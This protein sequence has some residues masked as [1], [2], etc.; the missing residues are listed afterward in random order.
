VVVT[1]SVPSLRVDKIVVLIK[2]FLR[3]WLRFFT[4]ELLWEGEV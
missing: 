4:E 3:V 2:R 1:C